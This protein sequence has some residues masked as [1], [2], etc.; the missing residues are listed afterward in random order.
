MV[1][2][3][4][5]QDAI[6]HKQGVE[7]PDVSR[8]DDMIEDPTNKTPE[9]EDLVVQEVIQHEQDN[10]IEASTSEPDSEHPG[11]ENPAVENPV[12]GSFM[13]KETTRSK[14]QPQSLKTLWRTTL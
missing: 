1:K 4:I 6:Q 8:R 12:V 7:T 3:T 2:E 5:Q 9:V 13:M 11:V 10:K 14:Y